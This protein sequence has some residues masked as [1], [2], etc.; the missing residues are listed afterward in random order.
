MKLI[1]V[2]THKL[3][4]TKKRLNNKVCNLKAKNTQQSAVYAPRPAKKETDWRCWRLV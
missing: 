2:K 1:Q 4:I 3:Y